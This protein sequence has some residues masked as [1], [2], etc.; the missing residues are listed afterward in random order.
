MPPTPAPSPAQSPAH[1]P[2]SAPS[3]ERLFAFDW[4]RIGAFGLLV[5]YHVGMVYVGWDW[6]VKSPHA[7]A[8]LEPLMRL[9][10]PWRMSLLFL[11]SGAAT[12]WM[13][14]ARPAGLLRSRARRLLLP[15]VTGIV[16]VVPP[17]PYFEVVQKLGYDG[18]F[19]DF[20]RLYFT[21]YGGFCR[22]RGCLV[23]PTWNHLWF[24]PYLFVYTALLLGLRRALP[25]AW[26]EA[27]VGLVGQLPGWALW[28]VPIVPLALARLLL[29]PHFGST[30]ALVDDVYQHASFFTVF[31]IGVGLALRPA[32]L[33]RL[34]PWRWP[35]LGLAL[36][37]WW[38]ISQYLAH[39]DGMATVPEGLRQAQRV[40]WAAQ[41]WS[42]IVALLGFARRHLNHDHRWRKP[43]NEAVFPVYLLHQ[44]LIIGLAVALAPWA[45][46]PLAEAALI[47]SLTLLLALAA[48]RLLRHTGPLRPWF[49]LPRH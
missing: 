14:Q 45:L 42:S 21:G 13:L 19:M 43:L 18:G 35:A 29:L 5:L 15:L 47:A 31:L 30:N 1:P 25:G 40:A 49:G 10:N 44:T 28:L 9:S 11:L 46:P 39:A 3:P 36:A 7:S 17:Q 6:H 48:W 2:A 41:Q 22:D 37:C 34:V 38:G 26:R 32:L 27:T 33:A 20:L 4:L 16:L 23:L 24:L 12:A 8:A